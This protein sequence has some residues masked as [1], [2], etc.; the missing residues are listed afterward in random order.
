MSQSIHNQQEKLQFPNPYYLVGCEYGNGERMAEGDDEIVILG[1]Y[2][3]FKCGEHYNL[4]NASTS[5]GIA[6]LMKISDSIEWYAY[7]FSGI[8]KKKI[9]AFV[10][11]DAG[12]KS[13]C[14]FLK[15]FKRDALLP[16]AQN[17]NTM[18]P[19]AESY[20]VNQLLTKAGVLFKPLAS[21]SL[22]PT[23]ETIGSQIAFVGKYQNWL[24]IKKLSIDSKTQDWEVA[25]ILSG[26]N[27]TIVNKAFEFA[28][29]S[30]DTGSGRKSFG[31]LAAAL[32]KVD[33]K[34]AYLVCKTCEGFGY[35]PYA[36]PEM[37]M[38][39]YPDIKAPKVKGRKPKG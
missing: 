24:A 22:K 29:A 12:L 13:V 17:K 18:L 30:G 2:K 5:D 21:T 38:A 14:V 37:L 16:A 3:Q 9:D 10:N 35:K 19:I 28:G 26:I 34:N 7:E 31:N 39:A 15:S 36:S 11:V 6:V 20:L 27:H 8:D 25:G 32:E 1:E 23:A 4:K 33:E